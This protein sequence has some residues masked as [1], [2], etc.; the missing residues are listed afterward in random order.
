MLDVFACDKFL[1]GITVSYSADFYRSNVLPLVRKPLGMIF[2][3]S[4]S[5]IDV[6]FVGFSK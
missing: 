3:G 4:E 5:A 1:T 6:N 2:I